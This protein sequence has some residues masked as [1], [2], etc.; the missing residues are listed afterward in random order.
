MAPRQKADIPKLFKLWHD[1][2]PLADICLQLG[3]SDSQLRRLI[4]A[5]KLPRRQRGG[6][7][8]SRGVDPTPEEMEQLLLETRSRWTEKE[9]ASRY[10]RDTGRQEWAVPTYHYD[11]QTGLFS[12]E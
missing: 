11:G 7:G 6:A 8:K 2:V 10:V 1:E 9:T 5:H 12:P 3:I 4:K